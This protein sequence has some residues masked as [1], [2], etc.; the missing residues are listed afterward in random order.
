MPRLPI[1]EM[2][3][4]S[5]DSEGFSGLRHDDAQGGPCSF[6][7]SV[8]GWKKRKTELKGP[9][10]VTAHFWG[11]GGSWDLGASY[12][13]EFTEETHWTVHRDGRIVQ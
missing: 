4:W 13:G 1:C 10:A 8:S 2:G 7:C 9:E 12:V 11:V 5:G 3:R 6:A